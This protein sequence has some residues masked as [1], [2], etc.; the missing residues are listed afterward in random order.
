ML[1]CAHLIVSDQKQAHQRG[2]EDRLGDVGRL[3]LEAVLGHQ[4]STQGLT[5]GLHVDA[6]GSRHPILLVN[7]RCVNQ[8]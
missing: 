8:K 5:G 1:C 7:L 4:G 6:T 3:S 2:V